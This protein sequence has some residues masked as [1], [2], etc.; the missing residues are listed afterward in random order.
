M[1]S[2]LAESIDLDSVA[3]SLALWLD[4][5]KILGGMMRRYI[6]LNL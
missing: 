3:G 4:A 5:S 1:N 6:I 2:S